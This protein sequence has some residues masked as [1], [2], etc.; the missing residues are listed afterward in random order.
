[1]QQQYDNNNSGALF[2]NDRKKSDTHPDLTGSAE[3]GGKDYWF[4]AW[5]K[6]SKKG[7]PFLSVSFDPIEAYVVSSGVAPQNDDPVPF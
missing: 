7:Q 4:K 1:M 2:T 5:K 3:V 6:T